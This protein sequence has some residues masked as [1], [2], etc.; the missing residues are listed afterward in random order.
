MSPKNLGC[1]STMLRF[2][3]VLPE[4]YPDQGPGS[5]PS[6]WAAASPYLGSARRVPKKW[7]CRDLFF[8]SD[9]FHPM[10]G[11]PSCVVPG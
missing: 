1:A 2:R 6:L 7:A 11:P 5:T 10:A 4:E 8:T 9:V 3:L